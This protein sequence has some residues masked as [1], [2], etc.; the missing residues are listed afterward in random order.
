[1]NRRV[2][3]ALNAMRSKKN[4]SKRLPSAS[5][6]RVF[7]RNSEFPQGNSFEQY[8]FQAADD[9]PIGEFVVRTPTLYRFEGVIFPGVAD[10]ELLLELRDPYPEWRPTLEEKLPQFDGRYD[11]FA[12]HWIAQIPL[13]APFVPGTLSGIAATIRLAGRTTSMWKHKAESVAKE[14]DWL[15]VCLPSL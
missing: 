9:E 4:V 2:L 5:Y 14:L 10:D 6:Y 1:M 12:H 15:N 7:D 3:S 13:L 8:L 11:P